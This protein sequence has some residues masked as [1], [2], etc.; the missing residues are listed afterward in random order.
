MAIAHWMHGCQW[1]VRI[2]PS[3]AK[4]SGLVDHGSLPRPRST[5][6][7]SAV[8]TSDNDLSG[9]RITSPLLSS[10]G[11]SLASASNQ[12]SF[13]PLVD[14]RPEGHQPSA[15]SVN[16]KLLPSPHTALTPSKNFPARTN[17]VESLTGSFDP[18]PRV[19][20][21]PSVRPLSWL[22]D[23][24]SSPKL[25]FHSLRTGVTPCEWTRLPCRSRD[26]GCKTDKADRSTRSRFLVTYI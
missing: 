16:H 9:C 6:W 26:D 20:R 22:T 10:N 25:Q 7:K 15:V 12:T 23:T 3:S 17:M 13:L 14:Q 18:V 21:V 11:A 2:R 19:I 24:M 1:F 5:W 8:Y 4:R